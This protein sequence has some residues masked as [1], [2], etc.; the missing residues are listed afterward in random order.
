MQRRGVLICSLLFALFPAALV[1][2]QTASKSSAQSSPDAL[3][4][5]FD[6][7]TFKQV[8][9]SPD[10]KRVAWVE[11]LPGPSGAPSSNSAIYVADVNAPSRVTRITADNSAAT[12]D[13]R[14][15]PASRRS[16]R[17][18]DKPHENP[19][20]A[21]GHEE[22]NV[23][24]SPDSTRLA[25]L[26]D[27]VEPHQ[28]QLYVTGLTG[29]AERPEQLT[30]FKGFLSHVRWSPDGK[31]IALLYIENAQRVAGP[32]AAETPDVGVISETY[33]EQRLTLVDPSTGA[34]R[35]IT[36][37]DMYAY[38]F[39]WAPDSS[40]LVLTA[41][42]GNGDDNWWIADM[43]SV[44][45]GSLASGAMRKILA[46]PGL[47][48]A[49]PR[50]SPDGSQIAFISGLMS[51]QGV[52]GG[53]IYT[54]PADGGTPRDVT[55]G[56]TQSASSLH[57][58]ADS[59]SVLFVGIVAGETAI[60]RVSVPDGTIS[61]VWQG[62]ERLSGGAGFA[63]NISLS[64]D[65]GSTAVI[66]QSFSQPPEVWA[67]AIGQW[68]RV[69]HAND[70]LSPAW[71]KGVSLRWNTSIGEV[72]GW[73]IYPSNFDP[74]KKY[75]MVVVV[76]GGPASATIPGWPRRGSYYMG[77]PGRGYFLLFP[78]PRGSYGEG[79]K[80]TRANVKDFGYGDWLDILAGVDKAIQSAPIDP[81]RLGLTGW[82]YGGYMTMWGVTQTKRFRA[83]VAG[84]GLA[85]WVSYYGENKID[86]WMIPYF[87][88]SV[89]DDPAVY[90]KS[91]PINF[92]KHASTP[93]LVVVGQY[94]GEC[95]APQSLEFWH[96]LETL[97]VPTRLVIYPNEGHGFVNPAHNRDVMQRTI[98]WFN[99]YLQ[100]AS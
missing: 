62:A 1:L 71:G 27:A 84:A 76:H 57:W 56:M 8:S 14:S 72:Q 63:P 17:S 46:N 58:A 53:D 87:G 97:H 79:E 23:A 4:D 61:Q 73:L 44:D 2:A 47:Q 64:R 82:S 43:Y 55:P 10:G 3:H 78:N 38:E 25:F 94:D 5:M 13:P 52:T 51:D 91:A 12:P 7:R 26:S 28:L 93:T 11:N 41:A 74:Q 32:L 83:A 40:R 98:D 49:D 16:H 86:Q 90:A 15:R 66:R 37:A 35:P 45:A 34:S 22:D 59:R 69:T 70:G 100:P 39:D 92:I 60:N 18:A 42:H 31:T 67:G 95:P 19:A 24:W 20:S 21:R 85:D 99:Q 36:P 77:L 9:I 33:S 75:P 30:H 89:Y 48:M 81:N 6:V 54:L 50:W 96:A 80:F 88:A 65:A 29:H 68:K